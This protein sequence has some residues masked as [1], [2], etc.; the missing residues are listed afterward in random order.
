MSLIDFLKIYNRGKHP[1]TAIG[2]LQLLV[3]NNGWMY[4]SDMM[5]KLDIDLSQLNPIVKSLEE[6][7]A[8]T[9]EFAGFD[10]R[11]ALTESGVRLEEVLRPN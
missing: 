5:K 7:K 9:L 1:K 6:S 3:Q 2:V 11:V 8:I 4:A 10:A